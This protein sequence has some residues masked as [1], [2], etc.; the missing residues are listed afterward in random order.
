MKIKLGQE[1]VTAEQ[2]AKMSGGTLHGA[3]TAV[4]ADSFCT[5]SG[6]AGPGT[7]FLAIKGAR[8]DG[9]SFICQAAKDGCPLVICEYVPECAENI[10]A[11]VVDDTVRALGRLAVGYTEK[12]RAVRIAVTGSVGKT[13]TKEFIARALSSENVYRSY[14]NYNSV[15]GMPLSL[16]GMP[17]DAD[18]GVF[19]CGMERRGQM[20]AISPVCRPH[21]AVI[22]NIG[23]SHLEFF[24][25]REGI[26]AGKLS[27]ADCLDADGY[28]LLP[29]GEP[30]LEQRLKSDRRAL[31]FSGDGVTCADFEAKD[32]KSENGGLLFDVE[33]RRFNITVENVFI[34]VSG[35][36]NVA[37]AVIACAVAV[38]CGIDKND[39]R[40]G[41]AE[42]V[43]VKMRQEKLC[44][45]GVEVISDCYNAS[46]ESMRAAADVLCDPSAVC[47]KR[48][49]L[50]GDM[51]ELGKDSGDYHFK[52]GRY[53][54]M[55]GTDV[56]ITFG[57]SA[58]YIANGASTVMDGAN[59]YRFPD[60]SDAQAPADALAG[61]MKP[62]DRV[63]VKASRRLMAERVIEILKKRY[64]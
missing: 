25:T 49:A 55:A 59:I 34:P 27:I 5:D 36:Y 10:P 17:A 13:T 48:I 54:A 58:G 53:F 31:S 46:P 44:I 33:C 21:I 45:G 52:V 7:V 11:V 1:P 38:L 23:T 19:E 39:I 26:A 3:Q 20:E 42:Y 41:L 64:S 40:R 9:H 6:E 8:I 47:G 62:G 2:I 57:P 24:G 18:F 16:M 12:S 32:I 56:L 15:I 37:A 63:I 61:I 14:G 35:K 22:T 30:L 28:L 50:L 51:Y 60:I 43:P 29:A 4:I